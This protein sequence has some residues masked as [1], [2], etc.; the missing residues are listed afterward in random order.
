MKPPNKSQNT[1][2]AFRAIVRLFLLLAGLVG[3]SEMFMSG[4]ISYSHTWFGPASNSLMPTVLAGQ[5]VLILNVLSYLTFSGALLARRYFLLSD[6]IHLPRLGEFLMHVVTLLF[7]SLAIAYLVDV[8]PDLESFQTED[9]AAIGRYLL[10]VF[11]ATT[12]LS[13]IW[14]GSFLLYFFGTIERKKSYSLKLTAAL[15]SNESEK[16]L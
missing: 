1:S 10:T 11:G 6:D 14:G 8:K 2:Q 4:P 7:F 12:V 5:V 16:Y 9:S 15:L 13:L 3:F